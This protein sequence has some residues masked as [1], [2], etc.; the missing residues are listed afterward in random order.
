LRWC[1]Q[2]VEVILIDKSADDVLVDF[3]ST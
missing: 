3:K 2:S 1:P